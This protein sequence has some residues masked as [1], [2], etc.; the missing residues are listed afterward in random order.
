MNDKTLREM[1]EILY[2]VCSLCRTHQQSG[3]TDG[4]KLGFLLSHELSKTIYEDKSLAPD[5]KTIEDKYSFTHST[6]LDFLYDVKES[7]DA[8]MLDEKYTEYLRARFEKQKEK[9]FAFLGVE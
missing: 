4:F 3:F 1:D 8:K 6:D 7:K 5:L 9:I 2:P